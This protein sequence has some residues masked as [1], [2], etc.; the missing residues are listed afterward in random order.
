MLSVYKSVLREKK[1]KK[2]EET[3]KRL[4]ERLERQREKL[5]KVKA[6]AAIKKARL[7]TA[8]QSDTCCVCFGSSEEDAGMWLYKC[9]CIANGFIHKD[10]VDLLVTEVCVLCAHVL[11]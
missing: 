9:K 2:Q 5:M 10:C 11:Y 7:G 3:A 6:V 1:Q 4:E 8:V